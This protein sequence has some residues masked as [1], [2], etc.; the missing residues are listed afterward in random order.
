[1]QDVRLS[2]KLM[3]DE[4]TGLRGYLLTHDTSFLAPYTTAWRV[5]PALHA[6][7]ARLSTAVPGLQ[8]LLAAR[9]QRAV[10][11]ERWA[12][13]LL[14][15]LPAGPSSSAANVAQQRAGK[16]L[17]DA[18]RVAADRVV[19]YLD[20]DQN[21]HLQASLRTTATLNTVL[22]ALAGGAFILLA[23]I[24][25]MTVRTVAQPLDRL[26]LAAEAIGRGDLT[27]PV[28]TEG[29]EEFGLLAR[30]MDEMRRQLH[31]QYAVAAVIG[32]TL[33]L[34]EAFAEFGARVRDLVPCDRV[35]LVLVEDDGQ[36]V[37]T[38][39]TIGLGA[40]RIKPGTRR[41]LA[42]SVYAQAFQTGGCVIHSDL[43]ALAPDE[44]S[45]VEQQ[46][47][48][49]GICAEAI[50]PFV[51]GGVTGALNLW[52]TQPG[53]YTPQ[54]LGPIVALAPL[55]A[56]AV[57]NAHMYGR[58]EQAAETLRLQMEQRSAIIATQND[59]ARS[60]LDLSAVLTLIA[61]RAQALTRASGAAIG[62]VDGDE[63]D[64][65]AAS[66]TLSSEVGRRLNIAQ[67]LTGWSVQARETV[68]CDDMDLDPRVHVEARARVG[69]RSAIIVPLYR[70]G[71]VVG[72]L[73]VVAP[74]AR[75]FDVTDVQTLQLMAG[76]IAG[77]LRHAAD[78]QALEQSNRELERANAEL[79]RASRVKSEFLA[80][81]SHEIRTPMNGVI[82]MI[83]LLLDTH[84]T[85][86]Q[87]E[88]AETVRAS[89]EALLA[90]INDI[91]DFSKIEAGQLNVEMTDLDVR[92]TVEDVV[93]L[94]AAQAGAKGLELASLVHQDV[95]S[96]LRGDPGRLRQ[97]LTNLLSNALKFTEQGEVVVRA[98]LFEDKDEAV[99]VRVA[100]TDTGMGIAPEARTHLFH[101]FSQVDSSTTRKYGGTG[102]GLAICT[103]LVEL[104][105][106]E[107][108]VESVPGQGST[109]WFTVRLGRSTTAPLAGPAAAE[110]R[111]KRVLIVDDNET[112]RQIVHYQI[113]SWGMRNGM[114]EDGSRAL[115]E[116][117]DAQHGG[118]PYDVAVLDLA[119]PGMDGLELARAIKADPA[120]AA[121]KLVMLASISPGERGANEAAWQ[122]GIDALLTKPVRHSQL[123][124]S[125]VL[126]LTGAPGQRLPASAS[127][128][129]G[130]AG[131][132]GAQRPDQSR[133][134][135]LVVED[136]AVNQRVAVR[137]LE[138][139]GYRADAVANGREAVEALA[140]VPYDLVLMDCQMPEMDGYA[141]TAAIRQ[142][143]RAQGTAARRTPIIAMTA[144]ALEGEAEKCLAAGMDDYISKPV[145][146]QRL[147]AVLT[148]WRPQTALG[149]PE[150]ATDGNV[151]AALRDLQGAGRPEL[152]AELLAV[153]LRDTPPRL[154]A[155]HEAVARADAEAL[156]RAAHSL[157][158]SSSQIGAVQ[159]A[160]LCADIEEQAGTTD[161]RGVTATLPRLD[162]AFGRVRAHL[163][164]LAGES[165][166]S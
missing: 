118:T 75:A 80:T 44:L 66:G 128:S 157:K 20:A 119:M 86:E 32:S 9:R 31:S 97:V 62:L 106:G 84:L 116:L 52:G 110:L 107:I 78:F 54:N 147:E 100:V 18:W 81:M 23:L 130:A 114:A 35:S 94:F 59:I 160:R 113:L 33:R 161:L 144:H 1:M 138:T 142:R 131:P 22:A 143:E 48:E 29:A 4:E 166:T 53:I 6:R 89:G 98:T 103:R 13:Q 148:R 141:A 83:G 3:D 21:A 74:Q 72:V 96:V 140:H 126:V 149:P 153:Y 165:S 137:M 102:L 125:L 27:R 65:R 91:L 57:D 39:Y 2:I 16:Q 122:A 150:E 51:K 90:I 152:L 101:P 124:K 77:A 42:G 151:L 10:A 111:G 56:A 26:R 79:A 135:V 99:V 162:E 76:F 109:F 49:E 71:R 132:S 105:G 164:A 14:A 60:E 69:A 46:L 95:P 15:H 145:T 156:R 92:Q 158:G 85:P 28:N 67:S 36:T 41:P 25:W 50:V 19:H 139:R 155:L 55:V 112:S 70:E 43:G 12:R 8:P 163:L 121:T 40:N 7:D 123:Y 88:Y 38:A 129:G 108:G 64:W 104:M 136:N 120:L 37:V 117:R 45:A 134:R 93:D 159:V 73:N 115:A 133:G 82:G 11:W 127:A 34:K 17:F 30:S 58:L 154:A 87:R 47:L 68:R 5:R 146:V 63:I 61:E 24:G